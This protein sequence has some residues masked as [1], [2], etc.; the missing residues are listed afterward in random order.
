MYAPVGVNDR[1]GP[2]GVPFVHAPFPL[3]FPSPLPPLSHLAGTSVRDISHNINTRLSLS[4]TLSLRGSRF[5]SPS[6][7]PAPPHLLSRLPLLPSCATPAEGSPCRSRRRVA[8]IH[9][10]NYIDDTSM[11]HEIG[12]RFGCTDSAGTI[13]HAASISPPPSAGVRFL[14]PLPPSPLPPPPFLFSV[15]REGRK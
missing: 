8:W 10:T 1:E 3:P 15:S 5:S 12:E 14:S 4:P 7:F 13:F 11:G 9:Y 2:V 6:P